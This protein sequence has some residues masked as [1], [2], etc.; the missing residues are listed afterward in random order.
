M[1]SWHSYVKLAGLTGEIT[2]KEKKLC[3]RTRELFA[4]MNPYLEEVANVC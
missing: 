3:N 4:Q 1:R 2:K